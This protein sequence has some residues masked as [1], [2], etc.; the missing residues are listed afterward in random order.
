MSWVVIYTKPLQEIR[1]K[2]NLERL[3]VN[4]Y[5]P[6]R[7]VE[8]VISGSIVVSSE[9]LFPRYI[10]VRNDGIFFNKIMHTLRNIR[11]VSYVV[12]FGGRFAELSEETV[13][14]MLGIEESLMSR[15][16]KAYKKGER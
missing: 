8:K 7:F 5:L 14:S 9:P 6:L 10:F 2:E 12:K 16:V 1:A 11:G 3:G 13:S 15:P 4:V